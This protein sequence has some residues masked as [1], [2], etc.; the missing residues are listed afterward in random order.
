[1]HAVI[2][3]LLEMVVRNNFPP[4]FSLGLSSPSF[5]RVQENTVSKMAAAAEQ[6]EPLVVSPKE[7]CRL[8]SCGPTKLYEL[9]EAGEVESYLDGRSR[10]ITMDSIRRRVKRCLGQSHG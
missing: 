7:A 3:V 5:A 9:I 8:L 4:T 6:L 2:R 10:K 1:M